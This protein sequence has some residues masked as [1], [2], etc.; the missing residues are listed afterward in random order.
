VSLKGYKNTKIGRIPEEWDVVKLGE[1][2]YS[3]LLTGGTPS[4]KKKEYWDG[5]IPW[6]VS[7]DIHRKY[8]YDVDGRITE[9]GLNNSAAKYLPKNSILVALN[10]QGRTKGT[11]AINLKEITCNQSIAAY[12]LNENEFYPL[13]VL[14]YITS[15]YKKLRALAGDSDR[16]GLNLG[17]LRG[18]LSPKPPLPEQSKIA[19][20]LSTVDETIE[21]TDQIIEETKQLKKGLMQKLFSE[22][23][24][25][26]RFRDTKVGRIPAEWELNPLIDYLIVFRGGASLKPSDFISQGVKVLP[27]LGVIPGGYLK[28]P[29]SKQQY[30]SEEYAQNNQSNIVDNS[31]IVVVL[32]DLVPSGPSI[33]LVVQIK[34]D[35]KYVLAQG[36]Y[37]M[38]LKEQV[39]TQKYLVQLSNSG[40]YRKYMKRILVGSTQVHITNTEYKKVLIPTPSK[41]EQ[42]QICEIISEVDARIEKEQATKDQLEQLKK[43]LMQVLLTG[44]VRVKV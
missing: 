42:Y 18:V 3:K 34:S 7:G 12:V 44:Q 8:I 17:L 26:T 13:F 27:K 10:G 39:I 29:S 37:G 1:S 23:I 38:R 19:E 6:M 28:I 21:K 5:H 14:N 30:C 32:R 33:G 40:W 24:G 2:K 11:T 31:F 22:G 16:A 43:G 36:V 25:H 4:T 15:Q 20:I 35:D 41:I 9:E